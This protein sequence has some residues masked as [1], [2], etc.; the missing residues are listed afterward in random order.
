MN[1]L[2]HSRLF[3][4]GS[5][6]YHHWSDLIP[7]PS[8]HKPTL[9]GPWKGAPPHPCTSLLPSIAHSII[10]LLSCKLP[11]NLRLALVLPPLTHP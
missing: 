11:P 1:I 6:Y 8:L 10:S 5:C 7:S 3:L 2:A 9:Q 4:S